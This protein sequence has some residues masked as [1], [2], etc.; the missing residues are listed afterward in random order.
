MDKP[1]TLV[2]IGYINHRTKTNKAKTLKTQHRKLK[3]C[4]AR[5]PPQIGE[6]T[7]VLV[8]GK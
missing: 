3:R 1:E 5:N 6:L 4:E 2:N 7:H 8:K